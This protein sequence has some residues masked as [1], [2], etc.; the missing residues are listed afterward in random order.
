MDKSHGCGPKIFPFFEIAPAADSRSVS[1]GVRSR[2]VSNWY[3]RM[4]ERRS[5]S[6]PSPVLLDIF[7]SGPTEAGIAISPEQALQIPE[8]FAALNTVASDVARTPLR[9]LRRTGPDSFEP[10]IDHPLH[11]LLN[12]LPNS[13]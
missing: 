5:V 13:E 7:S 6:N 11:E 3:N 8:V 12:S 10:A 2:N 9:L 1:A 4:F